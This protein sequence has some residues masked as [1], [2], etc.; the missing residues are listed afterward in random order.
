MVISLDLLAHELE[1]MVLQ[2]WQLQGQFLKPREGNFTDRGGFHGHDIASM[3]VAADAVETEDRA[4]QVKAGD[5]FHAVVIE[6]VGLDGA[7]AHGK[8]G[9]EIV[10]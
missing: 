6:K 9:S 5:L 7:G 3:L 10:A 8:D 1:E 4:G 2:F